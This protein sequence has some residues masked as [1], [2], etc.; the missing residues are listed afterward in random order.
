MQPLPFPTPCRDEWLDTL[1]ALV[2]IP[3]R[4]SST[5]GEEAAIQRYVAQQMRAAGIEPTLI[6]AD[7]TPGFREHPLC[8]GPDRDYA[9]RPTVIAE[10][11]PADAP[12]LLVLA[13]SDTV[14]ISEPEAWDASPFE[15]VRRE[16]AVI[17]LGVADDKWGVATI[18]ALVKALAGHA[19]RLPRRL[20]F[21][22]TVDEENG[23]GNGLLLLML[24][25]IRA[26]AALYLD[27]CERN[28]LLGN[29]GGSSIILRP[30]NGARPEAHRHALVEACARMSARRV[31]LF[32][33]H[34]LLRDNPMRDRS[35]GVT[36]AEGA[37]RVNFYQ[38]PGEAPQD[39]QAAVEALIDT[40]LGEA[41]AHYH[42]TIRTPWFEPAL[43]DPALP[44]ARHLAAA[45]EQVEGRQAVLATNAKQDAFVLTRHAGIP[46]VSYGVARAHGPGAIHCPNE[47]MD[48]EAGWVGVRTACAAIHR[49]LSDA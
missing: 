12:A 29:L 7:R 22:S 6:H 3:S 10:L 30:T 18:L 26:E 13:H 4:S 42:R 43:I 20:V 49:W 5:G 34:P 24:A 46:T 27:G 44:L 21:A 15:P 35:V 28:V 14:Q 37:L 38:L 40:T 16:G 31:S 1:C 32:D 47:R 36:C 2:R 17:G 19:H 39:L 11:G 25:G 45:V 23:V 48:I 8:C 33:R 9:D 41:A